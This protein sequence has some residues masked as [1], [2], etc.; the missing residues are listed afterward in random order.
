HTETV[1]ELIKAG[2]DI[3]IQSNYGFTAL[4]YAEEM[5]DYDIIKLLR[6]FKKK[7]KKE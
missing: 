5:N 2:A 6:S 4:D 1:K 3:N 7:M